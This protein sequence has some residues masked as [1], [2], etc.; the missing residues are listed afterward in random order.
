VPDASET[1]RTRS[2]SPRT[3]PCSILSNGGQRF[4]SVHHRGNISL[5][6]WDTWTLSDLDETG[7]LAVPIS[8]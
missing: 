7:S 6:R 5:T 3:D 1:T 2:T 4:L 8:Q